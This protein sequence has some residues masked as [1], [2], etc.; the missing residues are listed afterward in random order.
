MEAIEE[1]E[2]AGNLVSDTSRDSLSIECFVDLNSGVKGPGR[3]SMVKICDTTNIA[4]QISFTIGVRILYGSI[5]VQTDVDIDAV[6]YTRTKVRLL[7]LQDASGAILTVL[8]FGT[9]HCLSSS[10]PHRRHLVV[11]KTAHLH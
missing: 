6:C 5:L 11:E 2:F 4:A 3:F 10:P 9:S 1:V 7:S 8:R